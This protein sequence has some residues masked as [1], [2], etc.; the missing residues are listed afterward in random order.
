MVRPLF[1]KQK[2][3]KNRK[4]LSTIVVTLLLIGISMVAVAVVWGFTSSMVKNQIKN[5]E[6]CYGNFDKIKLNGEYTC[7]ERSGSNYYLRFAISLTDIKPEKIVVAVSA[8]GETKSYTITNASST[9]TGL[10]RYPSG[11]TSVFLPE[12]NGG[13][14]YRTEAFTGPIN[15]I[16]IAPVMAGVQCDMSD[17]IIEFVDCSL[18]VD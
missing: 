10:T 15:S 16:K 5:S 17:S 12:K 8:A 3:D 6:A 14:T 1:S 2:K 7:Y 4:G 11:S 13:Y 18:L 9:T